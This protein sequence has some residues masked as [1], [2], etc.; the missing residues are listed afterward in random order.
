MEFVSFLIMIAILIVASK[1]VEFV[2]NRLNVRYVCCAQAIIVAIMLVSFV[3]NYVTE[4]NLAKALFNMYS[5]FFTIDVELESLDGI[6]EWIY[7]FIKT[8]AI[9]ATFIIVIIGFVDS[10]IK[11]MKIEKTK[12]K[13]NDLVVFFGSGTRSKYIEKH[14]KCR[15]Q[16]ANL[17]EDAAYNARKFLICFDSDQENLNFYAENKN[18]LNGKDVAL[19][20]NDIESSLF[21]EEG[22]HIVNFNEIIARNFWVKESNLYKLVKEKKK[23]NISLIG[24]DSIGR[25]VLKF[26]L[27]NNIYDVNQQIIY[28]VWGEKN[29]FETL[30]INISIELK[31][32]I[33]YMGESLQSISDESIVEINDSDICII[34]SWNDLII[35]EV[36]SRA[37]RCQ[38]IWIYD[39]N[40]MSDMVSTLFVEDALC[41]NNNRKIS[42]FGKISIDEEMLFTSNLIERAKEI[43]CLYK[44]A[45]KTDKDKLWKK[46]DA[47]SRRSSLTCAEYETIREIYAKDKKYREL[48]ILEHARWCRFMLMEDWEYANISEKRP[49][50]KLHPDLVKFEELPAKEQIKDEKILKKYKEKESK[51]VRED[52]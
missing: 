38:N 45:K 42:L 14:S 20:V 13:L 30:D 48:C 16:Y 27:L 50:K 49:E 2:L 19:I 33:I 35:Q 24:L 52:A 18:K 21:D 43:N 31:D 17:L 25:N 10:I 12:K 36:V 46:L 1:F 37:Y 51:D 26:G 4:N 40:E 28:K 22:Y 6:N 5:I 29:I 23:L 9:L 34:N 8:A 32:S 39:R 7:Y 15:L 47:F 3:F 44:D 41:S 11:R